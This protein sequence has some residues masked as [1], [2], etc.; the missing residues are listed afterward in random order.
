[1][2][3]LKSSSLS[4][5][6]TPNIKS[7]P[8][9]KKFGKGELRLPDQISDIKELDKEDFP[10]TV[11]SGSLQE[12]VMIPQQSSNDEANKINVNYNDNGN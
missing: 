2:A 4:L 11:A 1:V 6:A 12:G 5:S 3:D 10:D 8:D 9:L 7:S